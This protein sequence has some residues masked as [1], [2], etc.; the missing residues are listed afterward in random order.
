MGQVSEIIKIMRN[1]VVKNT[2]FG[3]R[4]PVSKKHDFQGGGGVSATYIWKRLC[5]KC[6]SGPNLTNLAPDF[7]FQSSSNSDQAKTCAATRERKRIKHGSLK[8]SFT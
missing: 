6:Q 2:K 5:P 3:L 4:S 1:F 7:C 8:R